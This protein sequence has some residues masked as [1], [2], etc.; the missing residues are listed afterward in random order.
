MSA[1]TA[2]AALSDESYRT[3]F[4]ATSDAICVYDLE[5]FEVLDTNRANRELH[6]FTLEEIR[7]RGVT[8]M[9]AP[10]PEYGAE[11]AAAYVARAVAGEV[12]RYEWATVTRDGEQIVWDTQLTRTTMQGR[13][14]LITVARDIRQQKQAE[15]AL[16]LVNERLER[17]VAERTEALEEANRALQ[18]R[19]EHFRRIIENLNDVIGIIDSEGH[20]AYISPSVR[21]V[22][23]YEPE[24]LLQARSLTLI[25]PDDLEQAREQMAE[26]LANPGR[27]VRFEHRFQHADGSWRWVEGHGVTFGTGSTIEGIIV[28]SRD[29]TAHR[30]AEEALRRSEERFRLIAET[31]HGFVAIVDTEGCYKYVSPSVRAVLG[32][33]PEELIGTSGIELLHPDDVE[34]AYRILGRSLERPG[35]AI[36]FRHRFRR[37]DGSYVW[38]EDHGITAAPG[39]DVEGI[40]THTRD[41]SEQHEAEEAL[42]RSEELFRMVVEH[43]SDVA[44]ITSAMGQVIY[45]SP[46]VTRV[47]GHTPEEMIRNNSLD[48]VHPDDLPEVVAALQ[49]LNE[50]PEGV[51]TTRYRF[52]TR[53]GS[54]RMLESQARKLSSSPDAP[55]ISNS[56][57]ITERWEAEQALL[58]A[59]AEAER[60]NLA[61]SEFLSRMSHE[62]RTPLNSILGFAQILE[63]LDL[64]PRDRRGVQHILTAGEHLLNLINEVLDIARIEAGRHALSIEPV[65]IGT[66]LS[67][68][69]A[70]VRPLAAAHGVR[71]S[72]AP[73]LGRA[74][75]VRADRQRLIQ[76]LLNLL[77][78]AIKYNQQSGSVVLRC[79]VGGD[80]HVR[81]RVD[82][83]GRGIPAE[84]QDELFTPFA[85]L[86]AEGSG[87]EGTGLGLALSLRLVE[88]MGGRLWLESSS[89]E[90]STFCVE[91]DGAQS[92]RAASAIETSHLQP[93]PSSEIT[94][95]LLYVEDNLANLSLVERLISFR[96]GWSLLPALQGQLGV[97][98][99]REHRPDVVLLDLH[100]PDLSGEEVFRQ[101]RA[102]ARTA[103]IPV[104]VVSADAT[105]RSIDRLRAAGVQGYL[106]KPLR[107]DDFL[108]AVDA[109][110]EGRG[111]R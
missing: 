9:S 3:I 101:L 44:T 65:E 39:A 104:I 73:T 38:V 100:L 18:A 56:R 24:E 72:A 111:A 80:G 20:Y 76:V 22:F 4:D 33:D 26:T 45:Q 40:V 28:N 77:S 86:G 95:R 87:V 35:E 96:P 60:A 46:A 15:E 14:V 47:V 67:E 78:N 34:E 37:K 36:R 110:L 66:V 88:A 57:D 17:R 108:G 21:A 23:G 8:G 12:V 84:R 64:E 43:S 2:A 59:K 75:F 42:R 105:A 102:D 93:A 109:A 69:V 83:T 52:R 68:A 25:H 49:R 71:I 10:G 63:R 106:T 61:K 90:G 70:L 51:V 50:K 7:A 16:R 53:D 5:T 55:L 31:L 13:P 81:V 92:P 27:P 107:I 32:Y 98:L 48:L 74:S 79:E 6:G 103:E 91:L 58:Q 11:K 62:L 19:E 30:E 1:H 54:W 41:I 85:R 89:E 29:I 82:D 99:A 94:A 97:E